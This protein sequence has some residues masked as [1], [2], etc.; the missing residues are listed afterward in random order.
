MI[1]LENLAA[2]QDKFTAS[3]GCK[4]ANKPLLAADRNTIT[5]YRTSTY[6]LYYLAY[7]HSIDHELVILMLKLHTEAAT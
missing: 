2:P 7:T 5:L 1:H 3:T 4:S 6:T